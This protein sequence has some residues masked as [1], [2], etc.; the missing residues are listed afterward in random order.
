MPGVN[1]IFELQRKRAQQQQTQAQQGAQEA[2]QRRFASLGAAGS[3]AA[4][5]QEQ[6][7][8]QQV[9]QQYSQNLEGINVSE[10]QENQRQA[11]IKQQQKFAS[12]EANKSRQFSAEQAVAQRSFEQ[13]MTTSGQAFQQR[14]QELSQKYASG[15]SEKQRGFEDLLNARGIKAQAS[16]AGLDRALQT[17][18]A[19]ESR[20][21]NQYQFDKKMDFDTVTRNLNTKQ[22]GKEFDLALRQFAQEKD[23]QAFNT[24]LARATA[25]AQ[26]MTYV[27]RQENGKWQVVSN[28]R[29]AVPAPTTPPV[30]VSSY[31]PGGS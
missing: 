31:F 3:G 5:R 26:N 16:Q 23:A 2:I 4:I 29:P 18:L 28:Q 8:R 19:A 21:L 11:E 17:Q 15:E 24:A 12:T 13:Q 25:L 7:A 30:N 1:D 22:Q 10:A 9:Q 20:K 14:L 27:P 6:L